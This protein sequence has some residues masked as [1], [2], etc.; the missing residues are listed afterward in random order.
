M[1]NVVIQ[2]LQSGTISMGPV[3]PSLTLLLC[4]NKRVAKR[5]PRWPDSYCHP[6]RPCSNGFTRRRNA[7]RQV[8]LLRGSAG[9]ADVFERVE[10]IPFPIDMTDPVGP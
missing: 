10:I 4:S 6:L 8:V 7:R 9:D 1:Q 2:R 3:A 5:L